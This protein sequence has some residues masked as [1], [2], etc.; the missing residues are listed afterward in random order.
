MAT[1]TQGQEDGTANPVREGGFPRAGISRRKFVRFL[2]RTSAG[3]TLAGGGGLVYTLSEARRCRVERVTLPVPNLPGPFVGMTIAFLVD[4]PLGPFV[5]LH[6]LRGV[7]AMTNR[8]GADLVA[9]GGDFIQR[10]RCWYHPPDRPYIRPGIGVLADL[11]APSGRFAVLGNHDNWAGADLT[12]QALSEHG[13]RDLSNTGVWLERGGARLR[14]CGVEDRTT[15]REDFPAAIGDTRPE[16]ACIML[17]HNPDSVEEF[18]DARVGLVLSGHTHGGQVVLPFVGAPIVPSSYGQRYV[19]GFKQ[20]PST[21][22]YISRGVGTIVPPVRFNCPP[23]VTF[24]T[25][26]AAEKV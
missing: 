19:S 24:I 23:E 4:T 21:R 10:R 6:Y 7:V 2:G 8:L 5:C 3:L 1:P 16:D 22:V 26:R 13:I 12:R 9:L 20:G 17:A 25:L 11:H 15:S 18:H 14:L